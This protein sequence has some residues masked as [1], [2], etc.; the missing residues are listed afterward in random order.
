MASIN[1]ERVRVMPLF[2]TLT[3]PAV[4]PSEPAVWKRHLDTWLKRLERE[5][6]GLA[7]IWKLEFQARGAPHFHL[8]VFGTRWISAKWCARSWYEVVE[9]GDERHLLA[10]TEVKRIRSWR[11]VMS[12]ASKY[13][14]KK[15][16]ENLPEMVGRFWGVHRRDRL[17]V[18]LLTL[19]MDFQQ[20]F[21]LKRMLV[22]WGNGSKNAMARSDGKSHTKY[23]HRV[24]GEWSGLRLYADSA[25]L[26]PLLRVL[27]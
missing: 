5:Y 21:V 11:G 17:P 10:G 13:L 16:S 7:A 9:S 26:L 2:I 8:L 6:V 24:G 27:G 1:R 18:D 22:R 25:R 15:T 12:Y 20:F 4:W 19:P 3:Y 14:A 23:K